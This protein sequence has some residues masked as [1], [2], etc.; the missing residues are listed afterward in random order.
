MRAP[1]LAAA[2]APVLVPCECAPAAVATFPCV[3][4]QAVL[5]ELLVATLSWLVAT[6][7]LA[8]RFRFVAAQDRVALGAGSR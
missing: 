7:T 5:P 3:Q 1:E 4:A 2:K 6:Q 8:E